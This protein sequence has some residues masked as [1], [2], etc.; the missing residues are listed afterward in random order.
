MRKV[1]LL[2]GNYYHKY[3]RGIN[4][5]PIFFNHKNWIFFLHRLRKYFSHDQGDLIA[6]CLMP[7][8]YHLLVLL[9]TNNFSHTVMQPFTVSY[10]KAINHQEN[11]VGPLFQGPYQAK[12]IDEDRYLLHLSAYIHLN[13]VFA[14]LVDS[15]EDWEFSSYRDYIGLRMETMI[16]T[17]IIL[18]QFSSPAEYAF[19]V[20]SS[21]VNHLNIPQ[22]LMFDWR[23]IKD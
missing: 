11:R 3:N 20:K 19:F 16:D 6:Y 8:H 12:E 13:P 14:H 5:Q 21:K 10:T 4:K 22:D 7:N 17:K 1:Q 18:D 2:A 9:R 15:P 23:A